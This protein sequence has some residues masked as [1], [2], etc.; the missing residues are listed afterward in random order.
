[1]KLVPSC[2]MYAL[3]AL[4]SALCPLPTGQFSCLSICDRQASTV[5]AMDVLRCRMPRDEWSVRACEVEDI[6]EPWSLAWNSSSSVPL[7][8]ALAH[9]SKVTTS[10]TGTLLATASSSRRCLSEGARRRRRRLLGGHCGP[11]R[12]LGGRLRMASIHFHPC[13]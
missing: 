2:C 6:K 1:M 5:H 9:Y 7:A 10:L 3:C 4:R 12:P 13:Y 11:S 8:L